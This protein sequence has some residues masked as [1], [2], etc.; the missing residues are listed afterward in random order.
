MAEGV[1]VQDASGAIVAC[2]RAAERL[3]GLTKDQLSGRTSVDPRWRAVHDDGSPF[4]GNTHPAMVTLQT[5]VA[6]HGVVMGVHRPDGTLVWICINTQV[7]ELGSP[8]R[9]AVLSTFSDISSYK[10]IEEALR[11]REEC[12]RAIVDTSSEG[13]WAFD[14]SGRT[15]FANTRMAELLATTVSELE[16]ASLWDFVVDDD[17]G[18]GARLLSGARAGLREEHEACLRRKDGSTIWTSLMTSSMA[19]RGEP[20]VLAMVRDVTESR[21][22]QSALVTSN[23]RLGRALSAA[24]MY[25]WEIAISDGRILWARNYQDVLGLEAHE[26][27]AH[28]YDLF[29]MMH[30]DDRAAVA[31]VVEAL[32]SESGPP[33]MVSDFRVYRKDGQV[34]WLQTRAERRVDPVTGTAT[35][36]GT[37]VDITERKALEEELLEARKL[38]ALGRLAGGVAHDFNNLLTA[39]LAAV[40][41]A[42]LGKGNLKDELH[43]IRTAA[44]RAAVLTRQLLQFARKQPV[45]LC[46]LALD[47]LIRGLDGVLRRLLGEHA[48]LTFSFDSELW[49]VRADPHLVEQV[50]FNLIANA[51]D[52]LL[53]SGGTVEIGLRNVE[54]TQPLGGLPVGEYVAWSVH[55]D[56]PGIEPDVLKHVFEPF[57]TTKPLGTGLGLASCYGIA[58]QLGGHIAVTSQ[59]GAGC[60]FT[61]YLPRAPGEVV[62]AQPASTP[63]PAPAHA[64]VLLVEDEELI[65]AY[66]ARGLAARGYSV[67]TAG[68]GEEAL[69]LLAE[70]TDGIDALVSDVVLPHM[71]GP[72][73]AERLR[74]RAPGL[75]VLF[76]SGYSHDMLERHASFQ[77]GARLLAKPY[78]VEQLTSMVSELLVQA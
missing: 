2:N 75:P 28:G 63:R 24:R 78:T 1:V 55:D 35:L 49:A 47:G 50:L 32:S 16:A 45:A 59:K 22:T 5:G 10:R 29:E 51:R 38:E 33:S 56:G 36:F 60:T 71:S 34:R 31:Q 42:E 53:G 52:A 19:L 62:A 61:V 72:D 7:C 20:G 44:E 15:T 25:V 54:L 3:L 14:L 77:S 6:Q 76:V 43:T 13:I 64:T 23:E 48:S 65:R 67:I 4:P 70:R 18:A 26:T 17:A 46:N 30:P 21:R 8:A 66:A 39:M 11:E 9:H 37:S 73:L 68:S 58:K 69:R 40:D 41:F 57:Y 74:A 12:Y 27:F